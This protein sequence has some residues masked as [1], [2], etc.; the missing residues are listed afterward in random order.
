VLLGIPS[1]APVPTDP[2]YQVYAS[3]LIREVLE[4]SEG[5]ALVLFT[6]YAMLNAT[7]DAVQPALRDLGIHIFKQG[8]DDRG[9][10]LERFRTDASS[11]LFATHSFWEGIDAP[12]Q[13]LEVLILCRLPFRVPT[14]PVL[15]ARTEAVRRE[16]GN[17]FLELS[18]PDAAIKL[19]Q[20]FGRLMRRSSDHGIIL[21]LDSRIVRKSYGPFLLG[22]LPEAARSIKDRRYM[23]EDVENFL[24]DV[25]GREVG[26]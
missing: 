22:S 7:Y 23:V 11:V 3:D 12:G 15:L 6:S 25:R 1:D 18:L 20:G 4:I 5:R 9:R 13:S 16:G 26:A 19:K 10:L 8:E 24:A 14:E 21:I 17:P 2:D